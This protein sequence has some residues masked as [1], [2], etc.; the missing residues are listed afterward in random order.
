MKLWMLWRK[1]ER[2]LEKEIQHHLQMAAT[3]RGE[4]G[5]SPG[6]SQ[7]G[8]R[9]EFGNVGLVKEVTRD[10]WGWRWL[11]NL[12]EDLRYGIRSLGKNKGFAAVAILTLALGIGAN[13]AIFSLIDAAL[14]RAI[15][16][17]DASQVVV[18]EWRA[19]KDPNNLSTRSYGDC[20]AVHEKTLV[21]GCSLSE[22]LFHDLERESGVFSSVAAFAGGDRLDLSG[23]GD[24]STVDQPEFVSGKY[25]ETLGVKPRLGRL[26]DPGDDTLAAPAVVVL[27][28]NYW[29]SQFGAA[30][31]VLGRKILL[32]KIPFTIIGVAEPRFDALS[33]GNAISIWLPLATLSQLDQ[34][35]DNRDVDPAS[36]W[37][38]IVGRLK[39]GTTRDGAQAAVSTIFH[40]EMTSGPKPLIK[41]EDDPR[42]RLVPVDQGLAGNRSDVSTPLYVLLL[43]VGIVLLIACANVAGLML[44]RAAARQ[45]EM[46]VRFALGASRGRI[47]RQLLTESLL[48]SLAGGALGVLLASWCVASIV[49]FLETSQNGNAPFSPGIDARVLLFTTT[50]SILTGVLFG[51]A[52]ALR[53]LRVDLTPALKEGAVRRSQTAGGE[54]SWLSTGNGLVVAQVALSIVVLAGAGLLARTLQNLKN[55][56]PGFDTRNVLTF[57]LDPTLIGYKPAD[58]NN[59]YRELRTRFSLMPGVT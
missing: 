53:G 59:V 24:A 15:P 55:I 45:K 14:L 23:Q 5:A 30:P 26:I 13:T 19:H 29:R 11:E 49:N 25:F 35:W 32:N 18:L 41:V 7:A 1:H 6:E 34:P 12:H 42:I 17:R 40:S 56:D 2:D 27:S 58:V 4:R 39:S 9:R 37:L 33:P 3:E 22:P 50:I 57:S 20:Q 52:P 38:V 54:K 43:A 16:V 46:A 31:S 36:W 8:A 21:G 48:L 44:A 10:V 51:L 28:Y 47:L